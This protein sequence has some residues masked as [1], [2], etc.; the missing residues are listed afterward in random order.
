[1]PTATAE[2]LTIVRLVNPKTGS[3]FE[4]QGRWLRPGK[5]NMN[6][7]K[8]GTARFPGDKVFLSL[9]PGVQLQL[10]GGH[11]QLAEQY[12]AKSEMD[13]AVTPESMMPKGNASHADWLQYAVSQGMPRTEAAELS[14]DEIRARFTAPSFDPDAPP[15]EIG[16]DFE[17][18]NSAKP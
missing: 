13:A 2:S 8:R 7:V 1:V 15:Q 17:L 12:M 11:L 18:L 3:E 16:G 4:Y 9:P 5:A 6:D 14:R 10:D